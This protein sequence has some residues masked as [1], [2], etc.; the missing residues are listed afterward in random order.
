M[1]SGSEQVP[2]TTTHTGRPPKGG[3]PPR[4]G[5]SISFITQLWVNLG[6]WMVHTIA[7]VYQAIDL[8]TMDPAS[9][10]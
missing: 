7:S 9:V 1:Q 8:E 4:R 5:E 2:H 10:S 3:V 6:S